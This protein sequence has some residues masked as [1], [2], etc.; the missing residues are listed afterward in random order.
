MQSSKEKLAHGIL[1]HGVDTLKKLQTIRNIINRAH[2][3]LQKANQQGN[4]FK[5]IAHKI[6]I[7]VNLLFIFYVQRANNYENACHVN[8]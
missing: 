6:R 3:C 4:Y 2:Y 1:Q 7:I 8:N 5:N